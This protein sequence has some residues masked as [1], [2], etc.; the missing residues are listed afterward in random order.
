MWPKANVDLTSY[1]C[2]SKPQLIEQVLPS[3]VVTVELPGAQ[4]QSSSSDIWC[5]FRNQLVVVVLPREN[6]QLHPW[7]RRQKCWLLGSHFWIASR[8][9]ARSPS[10]LM[11]RFAFKGWS[12]G[13]K[14]KTMSYQL[15]N[16][17]RHAWRS[18]VLI[19]S[20]QWVVVKVS[21]WKTYTREVQ[22]SV[23]DIRYATDRRRNAFKCKILLHSNVKNQRA[24]Q[25]HNKSFI[26]TSY[27]TVNP[28]ATDETKMEKKENCLL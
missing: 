24:W 16:Q 7:Q 6:L 11:S 28:Q 5:T 12:D 27:T 9:R 15:R 20:K 25:C 26:A 23:T 19:N 21:R 10:D 8:S 4:Y 3:G 2:L 22:W 17:T 1:V 13:G 14:L 18:E